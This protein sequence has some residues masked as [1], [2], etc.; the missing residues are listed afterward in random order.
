MTDPTQATSPEAEAESI[1]I[2]QIRYGATLRLV[3]FFR[4]AAFFGHVLEVLVGIYGEVRQERFP[5][6]D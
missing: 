4:F 2:E 3:G 5:D 6:E 1:D